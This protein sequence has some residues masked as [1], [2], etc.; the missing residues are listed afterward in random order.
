M[1]T[2]QAATQLQD[3]ARDLDGQMSQFTYDKSTQFEAPRQRRTVTGTLV[4]IP[5]TTPLSNLPATGIRH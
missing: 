4:R 1:Q 3:L 5:A 2:R